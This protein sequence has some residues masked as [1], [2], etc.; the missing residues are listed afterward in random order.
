[1]STHPEGAVARFDTFHLDSSKRR[2]REDGALIVP[3]RLARTGIQAYD[4]GDGSKR[5]EFRP[6]E[7]VFSDAA[8]ASFD[9]LVVTDGHPREGMVTPEN[10]RALTRGHTRNPRRDGD[11][12]V[13][14]FVINDAALI[15]AIEDGKR[16]ELSGGYFAGLDFT[17][18][19][20][21]GQRYD[22]IQRNIRGNHG[23][24]IPPGFA[25]A[26]RE[27]RLLLDSTGNQVP[28]VDDQGTNEPPKSG[29]R[30][31]KMEEFTIIIDG[32]PVT[33]KGDA[34]AKATLLAHLDSL[35]VR[36]KS[37]STAKA[38]LQAKLDAATGQVTELKTKLDAAQDPKLLD[39]RA[40]ARAELVEKARKLGGEKLDCSGTDIEIMKRALGAKSEGREDAY[41]QARFDAELEL[42]GQG[43]Q[44][45]HGRITVKTVLDSID[46]SQAPAAKGGKYS[47]IRKARMDALRRDSEVQS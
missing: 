8:I 23:A 21:N 32:I 20:H 19:E 27:A 43:H 3:G 16:G 26:G 15:A 18:G 28:P 46:G 22:A 42:L 35:K 10:F 33:F 29:G 41:V 17:P 44:Q 40:K 25:R 47:M 39:T 5:H 6:P 45:G 12:L 36:A 37:D 34:T 38:E 1:M 7:E 30:N 9:D 31:D 13:V 14:D 2:R 24:V 11:F 4:Q